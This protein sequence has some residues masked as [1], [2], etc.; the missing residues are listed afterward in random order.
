VIYLSTTRS[1]QHSVINYPVCTNSSGVVTEPLLDWHPFDKAREVTLTH[2]AA[3]CQ[4]IAPFRHGSIFT[5]TTRTLGGLFR[6]IELIGKV[7]RSPTPTGLFNV[8]FT[9]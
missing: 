3:T 4:P 1:I 2:A 8:A 6:V 5:N 7:I 9:D